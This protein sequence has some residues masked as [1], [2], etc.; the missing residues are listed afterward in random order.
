MIRR[1]ILKSYFGFAGHQT[2]DSAENVCIQL[3]TTFAVL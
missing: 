2:P 1:N 3:M